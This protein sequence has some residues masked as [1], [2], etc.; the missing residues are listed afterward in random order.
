MLCFPMKIVSLNPNV[1][2]FIRKTNDFDENDVGPKNEAFAYFCWPC[3]LPLGLP[4]TTFS[5]R[6]LRFF[7]CGSKFQ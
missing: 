5:H 6:F 1:M 3:W 7:A 2:V 4:K